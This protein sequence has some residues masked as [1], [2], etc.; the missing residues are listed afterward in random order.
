V[1]GLVEGLKREI[2]ISLQKGGGYGGFLSKNGNYFS[3]FVPKKNLQ[4]LA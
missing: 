4:K 2:A 3:N 1:E